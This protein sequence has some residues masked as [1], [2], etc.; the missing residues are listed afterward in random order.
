MPG[1]D[2]EELARRRTR[3]KAP[4]PR[5]THGALAKYAKVVGAACFGA[6]TH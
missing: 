1:R 5:Y 4:T 6:V 2:D 3:W